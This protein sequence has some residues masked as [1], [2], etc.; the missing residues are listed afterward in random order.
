MILTRLTIT[1]TLFDYWEAEVYS[2]PPV[3]TGLDADYIV[4]N[5][6]LSKLPDGNM[7]DL[8]TMKQKGGDET[9]VYWFMK[10]ADLRCFG[11][12]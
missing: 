5:L 12:L 6:A 11:L 7:I 1:P 4:I 8:Y 9:K 2:I 10:I 3:L